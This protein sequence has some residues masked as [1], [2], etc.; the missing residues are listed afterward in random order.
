V[1][2]GSRDYLSAAAL[3][4]EG[5]A[6]VRQKWLQT[7][8]ERLKSQGLDKLMSELQ[9]RLESPDTPEEFAPVRRCYRYLSLR[10]DQLDYA[11]AIAKDLPIGSGEIESAHR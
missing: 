9:T 1:I 4:I 10:Q 8:K 3:A 11:G 5:E 7:Q 2:R 6:G